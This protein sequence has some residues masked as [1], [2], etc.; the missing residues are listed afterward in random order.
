MNLHAIGPSALA[1]ATLT[2]ACGGS[3]ASPGATTD[4]GATHDSG[5]THDSGRDTGSADAPEPHDVAAV[6]DTSPAADA[7]GSC[8]A[9]TNAGDCA[10]NSCPSGSV[11]IQIEEDVTAT[12]KCVAIPAA[13]G[14]TPSC[15]CMG[16]KAVECGR[17]GAHFIDAGIGPGT[18]QEEGDGGAAFLDL[19]CGCA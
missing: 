1:L 4:S 13:C 18:C 10:P 14:G 12:S 9:S 17:P 15:A 7:A 16:A 11:C 3:T 5:V 19:P 6:K 8:R 2:V